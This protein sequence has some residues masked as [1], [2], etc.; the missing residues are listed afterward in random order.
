[1]EVQPEGLDPAH[2]FSK[3]DEVSEIWEEEPR[4][5]Y[6]DISLF[7]LSGL[8]QMKAGLNGFTPLPPISHLTGLT[9][10]EIGMGSGTFSLPAS[11]WFQSAA[12]MFLGGI[13]AFVADAP[14]GTAI[15]STLPPAT[16]LVTSELSMS[17]LRPATVESERIIARGR[18]IQSGT[19][20]G[21]SEVL[22][23]DALG[24]IL[25]HGSC[26]CFLKDP[27]DP[28]PQ[29]PEK[30]EAFT[31]PEYKTPDPHLRPVTNE[32]SPIPADI[33]KGTSG[34]EITRAHVEGSLPRP[35]WA[36]LFGSRPVEAS[37][38]LAV[39]EIPA[40]GWLTTAAGTIYGGALALFA[41]AALLTSVYTTLPADVATAT[42]DLKVQFLRP[43]FVGSPIVVS[44]EVVH[45]GRTMAVAN[46]ELSQ[47]GKKVAL[48]TGSTLIAP[49]RIVD[50]DHPLVPADE[51]AADA[52]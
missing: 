43:V 49:G 27:V 37:E 51:P 19:K 3:G 35:P 24:R 45:K 4:G 20:L 5:G 26:R 32:A 18:L 50:M 48:A 15:F 36:R 34:L 39:L 29:P 13:S 9:M 10:V 31:E 52:D 14:L 40:T 33:R 11:P 25:A 23:E 44:S 8:D 2:E 41:D 46:C 6:P 42:L 7:G 38:G 1:M 47:G 17:F 16:P 21:L 30:L 12:G 22:V 28:A